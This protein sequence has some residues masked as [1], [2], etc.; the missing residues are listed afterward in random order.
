MIEVAK[1][2]LSLYWDANGNLA[3]VIGCVQNLG[4]LHEWDEE[5]RLRFVLGGNY[6]GA[7]D[8]Y[9]AFMQEVPLTFNGFYYLR[10][11]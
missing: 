3:Q 11:K 1:C 8:D 4:R 6:K 2:T 5:N 9:N 7:W 10:S